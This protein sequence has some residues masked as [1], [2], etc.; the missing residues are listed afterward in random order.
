M[1]L[2]EGHE[3][4]ELRCQDRVEF[5]RRV[6]LLRSAR[7]DPVPVQRV[8]NGLRTVN[9]LAHLSTTIESQDDISKAEKIHERRGPCVGQQLG[10]AEYQRHALLEHVL[11]LIVIEAVG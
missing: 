7:L 11:D 4:A 1:I 3:R 5:R 2:I 8:D 10:L 9:V 6:D